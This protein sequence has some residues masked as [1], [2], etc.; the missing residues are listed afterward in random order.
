MLPK[1]RRVHQMIAEI[2][3][4]CDLE[5]DGGIDAAT[6]PLV[7]D[8]GASV[9]VAGSAIFGDSGGV[10][11]AMKRFRAPFR[12]GIL[13]T[14]DTKSTKSKNWKYESF[15]TFVRLVVH[16]RFTTLTKS[17]GEN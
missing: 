10:T 16:L 11:G 12:Q 15:V 4:G 3:R 8:A 13:T 6:A 5:V 7:V 1:I 2:K 17:R 14:K 9:L